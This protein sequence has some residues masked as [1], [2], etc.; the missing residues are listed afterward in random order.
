MKKPQLLFS[1]TIAGTI[2]MGVQCADAQE[3]YVNVGIGYGMNAASQTMQYTESI[4][5]DTVATFKGAHGSL[6]KGLNVGVSFGYAFNKNLGVELGVN[7]LKGSQIKSTYTDYTYIFTN[8]QTITT[9]ANMLRLVPTIVLA[10]GEGTLRPYAK[11]GLVIGVLGKTTDKYTNNIGS[12]AY[13]ETRESS[14]GIAIGFASS[15]GLNI[16]GGYL[17]LFG[18]LAMINQSWAPTKNVMTESKYKGVDQLA[19]MT[20]YQKE[21]N[22]VDSYTVT[23]KP[24]QN[25]PRLNTKQYLPMSSFGINFGLRINLGKYLNR[26]KVTHN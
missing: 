20:T 3:P 8:L 6:A 7:Y 25:S 10:T 24:D 5:S 11:A 22:Y 15:L 13:E 16:V 21:T 23:T 18:E 19:S 14:G 12:Y 26:K 2:A 1:I 17:S 4:S 9:Q